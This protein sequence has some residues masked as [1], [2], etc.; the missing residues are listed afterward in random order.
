MST[1]G[2]R[3]V[4]EDRDTGHR[5]VDEDRDTGDIRRGG[6]LEVAGDPES[7]HQARIKEITRRRYRISRFTETGF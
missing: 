7:V 3:H 6:I 2:H 5:H 1:A 4:D